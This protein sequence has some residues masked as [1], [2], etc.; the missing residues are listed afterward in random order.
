LNHSRENPFVAAE[1]PAGKPALVHV[2]FSMKLRSSRDWVRAGE[3]TIRTIIAALAVSAALAGTAQAQPRARDASPLNAFA[4]AQMTGVDGSRLSLVPFTRGLLREIVT[5]EGKV[6]KTAFTLLNDR[7]GMVSGDGSGNVV[8]MFVL[9]GA[10]LTTLYSDGGSETLLLDG[11]K[12]VAVV[13]QT[14]EGGT[15]CT[16]WYPAGHVFTTQERKAA[17]AQRA[18]RLGLKLTQAQ[19]KDADCSAEIAKVEKAQAAAPQ[20]L[21]AVPVA[22]R[23]PAAGDYGGA[24]WDAFY[25][26]FVAPQEGGYVSNDG[27]GYPANYGINQGANPDVDV[28]ALRQDDAKQ[29]LYERYWLA[30]GADRL[31]E[32]LAMVHG[33]TAINMGVKAANELLAQ[34]GDDPARYLE[35]RTERYHSI[36][37]ANPS[38]AEYLPVWLARV[39]GLRAMITGE[40]PAPRQNRWDD[41]LD[42]AWGEAA[43]AEYPSER[44]RSTWVRGGYWDAWDE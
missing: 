5:P 39:D 19:V 3:K 1:V 33:D 15:A 40:K 44:R 29:I 31:P 43:Y 27:N 37:A 17:L 30:S 26:G 10:V 22:P 2:A 34:A 21:A 25:A 38:K 8:G 20:K 13:A 4:V 12:S 24:N 28:V 14:L 9:E 32:A 41:R 11:G 16:A 36:A 6:I 18:R 23:A 42:N 7:M 35:L